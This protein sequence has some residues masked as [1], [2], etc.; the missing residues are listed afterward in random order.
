MFP[1]IPSGPL[2]TLN[3][4][5]N[6][7]CDVCGARYGTLAVN[8]ITCVRHADKERTAANLVIH[9]P[10]ASSCGTDFLPLQRARVQVRCCAVR[11]TTAEMDRRG[12]RDKPRES[13]NL[14]FSL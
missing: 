6:R 2:A 7:R 5:I 13:L 10:A 9:R 12:R 14:Y 1:G 8:L 11:V 4:D 3:E